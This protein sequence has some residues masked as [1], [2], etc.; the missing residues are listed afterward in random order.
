[1]NI[2]ASIPLWIGAAFTLVF[3]GASLLVVVQKGHKPEFTG[4]MIMAGIVIG[5]VFLAASSGLAVLA[6]RVA[7]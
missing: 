1:M 4:A 7:S 3:G 6:I 5:I 2:V